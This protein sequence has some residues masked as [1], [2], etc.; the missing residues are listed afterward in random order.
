MN[1]E[2]VV[3]NRLVEDLEARVAQL[4]EE[5]ARLVLEARTATDRVSGLTAA[6]ADQEQALQSTRGEATA[7]QAQLD[8]VRI[9]LT[10]AT[11]D[12]ATLRSSLTWRWSA[13]IRA[14]LAPFMRR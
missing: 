6:L 5:N 7:A 14:M 2:L 8:D 10:Q 11:E 4:A 13:P 1:V 12:A 3:Q 9:R